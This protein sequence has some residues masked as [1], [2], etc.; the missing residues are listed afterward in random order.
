MALLS[1]TMYHLTEVVSHPIYLE[2]LKWHRLDNVFVI[3]GIA[4]FVY[5]L[6]G[7]GHARKSMYMAFIISILTQEKDP[8]NLNF[9]I[10]PLAIYALTAVVLKIVYWNKV[11]VTYDWGKLATSLG[12]LVF[13][14][15][16]YIQGLDEY[17]D[18]LRLNHGI[19]HMLA[20]IANYYGMKCNSWELK[21]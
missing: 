16:F 9:T 3:T 6:T 17:S 20:S 4:I 5:H 7:S 14:A 13:G 12:V 11:T 21:N 18:Y 8:W 15:Y 19:W 2:E 10:L 1:S